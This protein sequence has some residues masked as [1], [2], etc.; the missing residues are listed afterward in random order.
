MTSGTPRSRSANPGSGAASRLAA[1]VFLTFACSHGVDSPSRP[2]PRLTIDSPG[3]EVVVGTI[4]NEGWVAI[5]GR[6]EVASSVASIELRVDG[7]RRL[8]LAPTPTAGD[9]ASFTVDV[10][11]LALG[12][13]TVALAVHDVDGGERV[14]SVT[15]IVVPAVREIGVPDDA[16]DA[17]PSAINEHGEVTGYWTEMERP[18]WHAFLHS[19]GQT[20]A[21][22]LPGEFRSAAVDINDRG[23]VVGYSV[24]DGALPVQRAILWGA[25]GATP[26][27]AQE[28]AALAV[29]EDGVVTGSIIVDDGPPR[30]FRLRAGQLTVFGEPGR[31][32]TAVAVNAA[33]QVAG[34]SQS[35]LG[36]AHAFVRTADGAVRR[37]GDFGGRVLAADMNDAGDVVGYAETDGRTTY[38]AFVEHD[39]AMRVLRRADGSDVASYANGV[40]DR[41]VV[42]GEM[43][44]VSGGQ[45][46]H[47]AF[48]ATDVEAIAIEEL[49]GD[50]AP[51]LLAAY[52]IS[53]R[54]EIAAIAVSSTGWLRPVLVALPGGPEAMRDRA[55]RA[56]WRSGAVQ[57]RFAVPAICSETELPR[58]TPWPN[59]VQEPSPRRAPPPVTRSRFSASPIS[60]RALITTSSDWASRSTGV[61]ATAWRR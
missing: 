15:A 59:R 58:R 14:H 27:F 39:R 53:D 31:L 25:T 57:P 11:R 37:L 41:A 49:L 36:D 42:V 6:I 43:I 8:D 3:P 32:T 29:N 21:L 47:W 17:F 45:P 35:P 23:D 51:V 56:C 55:L 52:A 24:T 54:G 46:E 9:E 60:P 10:D 50:G 19:G 16:A 2:E 48:L 61:P 12:T 33:G 44:T 18:A 30:G 13:H 40:N 7:E 1:I 34:T 4:E 26:L 5:R 38:R 22:G 20:R 28:G